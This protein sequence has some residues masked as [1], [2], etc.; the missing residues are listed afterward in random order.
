MLKSIHLK[1]EDCHYM[2]KSK[3]ATTICFVNRKNCKAVLEGKLSLSRKL[4]NEKLG[5]QSDASIFVCEKLT[6]YNQ[7]LAWKC[8]ELKRAGK[9]HSYWSAK[10]VVKIRRTM[11]ERSISITHD[12]NIASLYPDFVFK[13]KI[14]SGWVAFQRVNK[15]KVGWSGCFAFHSL[16]NY[17]YKES[18]KYTKQKQH[19]TVISLSFTS[20][21]TADNFC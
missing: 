7:H 14:R 20:V 11:N 12:T 13:V 1:I 17:D 18:L 19:V 16:I 9:I 8:R 10:G 6:P 3:K 5:F 15:I 2:G 21:L 4:E